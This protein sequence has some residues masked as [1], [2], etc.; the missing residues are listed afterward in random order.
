M[1]GERAIATMLDEHDQKVNEHNRVALADRTP[2]P[3]K[4]GEAHF[5]GSAACTSCHEQAFAWW[6]RTKHGNAYAT[7]ERGHKEYNLNCVSSHVTGYNLPGGSTV[8]HVG[9]L[10]DVGC[11]SCHG[12][13]SK[14]VA[15]PDM[16]GLV[17]RQVP[18]STCA[19]CH[20]HEHS[21]RFVYDAFKAML[22]VPGHGR[23]SDRQ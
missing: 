2:L 3:A 14:H 22:I 6:Q 23:P 11:E 8:T 1:E 20:T 10:K 16:K 13:G 7:L 12:A 18:E 19:G 4:P 5:V 15:A 9:A 21:G 17:A